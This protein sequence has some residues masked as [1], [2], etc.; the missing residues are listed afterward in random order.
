MYELEEDDSGFDSS[1][2]K[3]GEFTLDLVDAFNLTGN[4][5]KLTGIQDCAKRYCP[6]ELYAEY[7]IEHLKKIGGYDGFLSIDRELLMWRED[8]DLENSLFYIGEVVSRTDN[9]IYKEFEVLLVLFD[10]TDVSKLLV[11]RRNDTEYCEMMYDA[12]E[13]ILVASDD[14]LNGRGK[15]ERLRVLSDEKYDYSFEIC[16]QEKSFFRD[17]RL[18]LVDE[19]R[20]RGISK[21]EKTSIFKIDSKGEPGVPIEKLNLS[22][23]TYNCLIRAKIFT[24]KDIEKKSKVELRKIRN[25]GQKNFEELEKIIECYGLKLKED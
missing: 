21:S 14:Y 12:Q 16:A 4:V 15:I 23:R 17:K 22:T 20:T 11:F 5:I 10:K 3:I 9:L 8:I 24:L 25:L 18:K 1:S 7:Q 19:K 6:L 2:F 13:R